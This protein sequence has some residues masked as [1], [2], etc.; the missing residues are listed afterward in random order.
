[1]R[2]TLSDEAFERLEKLM[3]IARFRSY[4]STVEECIRTIYE[5]MNDIYGIMG[6][7]DDPARQISA[8]MKEKGFEQIVTRMSRIT[9]KP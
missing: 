5:I 4:S 8:R 9:N 2:I 3:K 7:P 6:K 1:M